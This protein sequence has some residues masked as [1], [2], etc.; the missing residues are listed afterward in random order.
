MNLTAYSNQLRDAI[1]SVNSNLLQ[2]VCEEI[3]KVQRVFVCGNG[4]CAS[5]CDHFHTDFQKKLNIPVIDLCASPGIFTA[6]INDGEE[7]CVFSCLLESYNANEDDL[8]IC[9]STSGMSQNILDVL[10]NAAAMGIR[11]VGF[12]GMN[13]LAEKMTGIPVIVPS[14]DTMILEDSFW[15][16]VHIMV[17]YLL[18]RQQKSEEGY[19]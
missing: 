19:L 13:G 9:F 14:M 2:Q 12:Y 10:T 16:L 18:E 17:K 5:I 11:T 15:G 3:E 6:Y 7:R 1:S 4:D 8:L